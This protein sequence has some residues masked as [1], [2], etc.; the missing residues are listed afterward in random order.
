VASQ[1]ALTKRRKDVEDLLADWAKSRTSAECTRLLN[2]AGVP[3]GAYAAA[4]DVLDH[5]HL[6]ARGAFADLVDADGAFSVLNPPF[7]FDGAPPEAGAFVARL[8]EHTDAVVSALSPAGPAR[9]QTVVAG[10]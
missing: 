8:G 1:A 7:R 3:C 4:K 6:K 9:S 2:G 10:G 5:P